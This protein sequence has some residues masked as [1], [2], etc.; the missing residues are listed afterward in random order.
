VKI[1][2]VIEEKLK[3]KKVSSFEECKELFEPE[4]LT[5]MVKEVQDTILRLDIVHSLFWVIACE[6]GLN[7]DKMIHSLNA[8]H[9][10]PDFV[11]NLWKV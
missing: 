2:K 11:Q 6:C 3:D 5:A 4:N 9:Q 8:F 7:R 1:K 10:D